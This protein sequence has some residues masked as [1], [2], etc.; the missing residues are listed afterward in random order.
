M[1]QVQGLSDQEVKESAQK[2]G[3][4]RLTEQE[5]HTFLDKLIENLKDPMIMILIFAL[6]VV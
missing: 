4:N 2:N 3:T 6:V 1:V 5:S